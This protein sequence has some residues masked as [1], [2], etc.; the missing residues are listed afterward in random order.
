MEI[1]EKVRKYLYENIGHMTTA[2]TPK[3]DLRENLWKV[4][5]LCKTERGILI[6]GEFYVDKNGNFT[7]IPTKEEM[8]KTVKNEMKKLPFLYY[9]T[10]KEL[11]KQKIKPVAV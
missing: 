11:D 1:F 4:P 2:G 9:G 7:N 5:V 3:Y 6:V 8:L 10:R